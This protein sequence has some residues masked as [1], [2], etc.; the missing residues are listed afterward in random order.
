MFLGL[1]S[2]VLLYPVVRFISHQIP[3]KP[4]TINVYDP[5]KPGGFLVED[6]FVIFSKGDQLWATS[7]K[8]THLGCRLNYKEQENI[9]ECPCHQSRFSTE[10]VVLNGPSQKNLPRYRV[11]RNLDPSSFTVVI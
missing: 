11:E 10:G 7:R 2:I 8:C 9:L 1:C 5:L 3:R 4:V 6:N